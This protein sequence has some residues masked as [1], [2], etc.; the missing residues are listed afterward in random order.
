MAA[1]EW[2][3]VECFDAAA[4]PPL[5]PADLAGQSASRLRLGVQPHVRLLALRHPV[6]EF[7]LAVKDAALRGDASH[8]VVATRHRRNGRVRRP[9]A[10]PTLPAVH[11]RDVKI[12]YKPL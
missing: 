10:S 3:Q 6:D 5:A 8:A 11:R 7:A 4:H 1:F 12:Y 9:W 2:A